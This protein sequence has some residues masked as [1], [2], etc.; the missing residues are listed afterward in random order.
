MLVDFE[1]SIQPQ[2]FERILPPFLEMLAREG[3]ETMTSISINFLGWGH[4]GE[5]RQIVDSDGR[6]TSLRV[7]AGVLVQKTSIGPFR[8]PEGVRFRDRPEDAEFSLFAISAG[9]DD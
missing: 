3:V 8:L 9:H 4:D 7:D 1:G 2:D 5:R 6:I